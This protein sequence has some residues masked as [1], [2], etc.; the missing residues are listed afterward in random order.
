MVLTTKA[1]TAYTLG[2]HLSQER[3]RVHLYTRSD[4]AVRSL[5]SGVYE[6]AFVDDVL[7]DARGVEFIRQAR[8]EGFETPV[9][10][11]TRDY[12]EAVSQ[13]QQEQGIC[14]AMTAPVS[15]AAIRHCLRLFIDA[16]QTTRKEYR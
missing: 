4:E 6:I 7:E 12:G 9:A 13:I 5:R 3:F 10:L 1:S 14:R 15:P 16:V 11:I 2:E 8:R